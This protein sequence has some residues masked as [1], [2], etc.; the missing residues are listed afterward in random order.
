M[1]REFIAS[2]EKRGLSAGS[3][4]KNYAPVRAMFATAFED[5]AIRSNPAQ[6]RIVVRDGRQRRRPPTPTR[7]QFPALL[8]AL[9]E[10]WRLL[11]VFIGYT[12][13]RISEALGLE[14]DDISPSTPAACRSSVSSVGA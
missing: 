7:E 1:M 11:V 2:M 8:D 3:I 6:V 12:G 9:P 5:G 13:V 10:R 4:R 14:A